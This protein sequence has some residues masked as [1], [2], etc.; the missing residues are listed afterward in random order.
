[1]EISVAFDDF[2]VGRSRLLHMATSPPEYV[3]FARRL[4]S[5]LDRRERF[6]RKILRPLIDFVR[7]IGAIPIAE[8][9]ETRQELDA[10][11]EAGFLWAQGFYLGRP[12]TLKTPGF[13]SLFHHLIQKHAVR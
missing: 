5:G 11:R 4:V 2:G 13:G 3:K 1:M 6:R 12:R 7:S 8:G 9:V 10:C